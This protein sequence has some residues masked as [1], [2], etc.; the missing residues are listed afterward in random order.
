VNKLGTDEAGKE[1]LYY[2]DIDVKFRSI[3]G[4]SKGNEDKKEGEGSKQEG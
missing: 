1:L 3:D 4:D 2:N